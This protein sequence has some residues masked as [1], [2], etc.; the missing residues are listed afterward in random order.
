MQHRF[1]YRFR[2]HCVA[3]TREDAGRLLKPRRE[4]HEEW[5]GFYHVQHNRNASLAKA[6][7]AG[8]CRYFFVPFLAYGPRVDWAFVCCRSAEK[9]TFLDRRCGGGTTA[10]AGVKPSRQ[11]VARQTGAGSAQGLRFSSAQ[12]SWL[13]TVSVFE[14]GAWGKYAGQKKP[15]TAACKGFLS[16]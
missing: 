8:I 10:R 2:P 9:L 7:C 3:G 16:A 14:L 15:H 1:G 4:W 6:R 11:S 12:T 13:W 5:R